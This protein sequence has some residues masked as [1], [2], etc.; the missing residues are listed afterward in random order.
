MVGCF[1]PANAYR[2]WMWNSV[3]E[4][5][6]VAGSFDGVTWGSGGVQTQGA[7]K[8]TGNPIPEPATY[9]LLLGGLGLLLV[10]AKRKRTTLIA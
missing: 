1:L 8:I 9:A 4:V 7:F 2:G 3:S 5:G 10:I 6:E